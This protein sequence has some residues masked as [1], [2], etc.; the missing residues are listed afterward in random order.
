MTT[1][2]K[3]ILYLVHS[4]HSF[5]KDSIEVLAK[6]FRN[7]Y[8][9]V[10]YK[11]LAEI[12]NLLKIKKLYNHRRSFVIQDGNKLG[13]VH[14]YTAALWY[15]PFKFFYDL[16]GDYHFRVADKI[17]KRNNIKFDLIHSHFTWTAGY[18]GAKLKE[19]YHKPFV[20]TVHEDNKWFDEELKSKNEKK[21]S[22]WRNADYLIRVNKETVKDLKTFNKNTVYLPN[23]FNQDIFIKKDKAEARRLLG[24]DLK[25]KILLSIGHL[26]E[27]KGHI[28]L[29]RAVNI[30]VND[31]GIKNLKL[32]IIGEGSQRKKLENEIHNLKIEDYVELLGSKLHKDIPVWMNSCDVFVLSSLSESFGIVQLEAFAC[33]KPVVATKNEGSR[34]VITSDNLGFLCNIGDP[35]SLAE[36][37][38]KALE[39]KWNE[40]EII[41]HAESFTWDNVLT[42]VQEIYNDLLKK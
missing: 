32:Y 29:I 31:L 2:N 8:V 19:K 24:I 14:I 34:Q 10:R 20:L 15:L 5:Q 9:I 39:K 13:N 16:L 33:G 40:K 36:T 35:E 23:G 3:D 25:K 22:T 17:I 18:V 12:S 38:S 11:P 42:K 6:N 27:Y 41:K 1:K 28:Y 7:V 26:E 37:I 4:Y 30:L 21:Y